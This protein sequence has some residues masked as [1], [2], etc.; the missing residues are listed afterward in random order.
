[1]RQQLKVF[2]KYSTARANIDY[3][4]DIIVRVG[5]LFI[6]GADTLTSLEIIEP[7]GRVWGHVT[8]RHL[9]RLGNANWATP[10]PR[11]A[12]RTELRKHVAKHKAQV[13][14]F[15]YVDGAHRRVAQVVSEGGIDGYVLEGGGLL[16][17]SEITSDNVFLE[18]E[19]TG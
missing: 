3:Q 9:Q 11:F 5:N 1:M 4:G 6:V 12:V 18:S 17:D 2:K 15:V 16:L 7:D 13:G 8:T 19:V 10:D 14:D